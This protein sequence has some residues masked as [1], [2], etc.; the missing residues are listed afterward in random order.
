MFGVSFSHDGK[1][2][3]TAGFKSTVM[4]LDSQTL[5][6][7]N[8][9]KTT[10]S[11]Q[12][13]RISQV[14]N[15][16]FFN[17]LSRG[18][19]LYTLDP[20]VGFRE[21]R[22]IH[23][24]SGTGISEAN[25]SVFTVG[26]SGING[27]AHYQLS[28]FDESGPLGAKVIG[29]PE[30]PYRL[31]KGRDENELLVP[32]VTQAAIVDGLQNE[33]ERVWALP[34]RERLNDFVYWPAR[35]LYLVS[36]NKGSVDVLLRNRKLPVASHQI[37]TSKCYQVIPLDDSTV[38]TASGRLYNP[39]VV[40]K[41]AFDEKELDR[42]RSAKPDLEA[43]PEEGYEPGGEYDQ[44]LI[45][46]F[47]P[48]T[49]LATPDANKITSAKAFVRDR[50]KE[51]YIAGH[52]AALKEL[53][54][55]L[56]AFPAK[57]IAIRWVL[58]DEAIEASTAAT[59]ITSALDTLTQMEKFFEIDYWN[60]AKK[61]VD[62]IEKKGRRY[63]ADDDMSA[64][65]EKLVD[66]A[67]KS[68]NFDMA[69]NYFDKRADIAIFLSR[70]DE[71]KRTRRKYDEFEE[72]LV[73]LKKIHKLR[74]KAEES[75]ASNPNDKNAN[76]RMGDYYFFIEG[77]VDRA[78]EYWAKSNSPMKE[79][80]RHRSTYRMKDQRLA[81]ALADDWFE[82]INHYKGFLAQKMAVRARTLYLKAKDSEDE[83]I[84]T[85]A[86]QQL[87]VLETYLKQMMILSEKEKPEF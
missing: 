31:S 42:L 39:V 30:R 15:S 38:I 13:H 50:Y 17:V 69:M 14:P 81:S 79:S 77:D 6:L 32:M 49:K 84:A 67:V 18:G 66:F 62:T 55:L 34:N 5:K 4:V 40:W 57:S 82:S 16:D 71:G 61:I 63:Y 2:V 47:A 48:I 60:R 22:R 28:R 51:Y 75:L 9:L 35:D 56:N 10:K 53:A 54:K 36:N 19:N 45:A 12:L 7:V 85:K 59:D 26:S 58:W 52:S 64:A 20:E 65:L 87:K 78:A 8:K 70:Y 25:G 43:L 29:L 41:V 33:L 80:L 27:K 83:E 86:A 46:D 44:F 23:P 11:I 74:Q 68:N 72:S 73:D 3:I 76:C 21:R 1:Y 24:Q 37:S